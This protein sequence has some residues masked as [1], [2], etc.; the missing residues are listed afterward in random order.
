MRSFIASYRCWISCLPSLRSARGQA[1]GGWFCWIVYGS[2]RQDTDSVGVKDK[3]YSPL[4][5]TVN[6]NQVN[7]SLTDQPNVNIKDLIIVHIYVRSDNL[8][9]M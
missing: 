7:I 5:Q 1:D 8:S 3:L 6:L 4:K 2:C 9:C